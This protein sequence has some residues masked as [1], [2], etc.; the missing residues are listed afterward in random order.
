V[1]ALGEPRKCWSSRSSPWYAV[2][3]IH[4]MVWPQLKS[5]QSTPNVCPGVPVKATAHFQCGA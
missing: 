2:W 1:I 3:R 4:L 5:A